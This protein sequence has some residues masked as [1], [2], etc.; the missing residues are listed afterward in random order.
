[1]FMDQELKF[2]FHIN[3]NNKKYRNLNYNKYKNVNIFTKRC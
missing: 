2:T 1:M 3:E